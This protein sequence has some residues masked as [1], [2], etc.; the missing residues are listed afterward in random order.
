MP[1]SRS[2]MPT[3]AIITISL[4]IRAI[5]AFKFYVSRFATLARSVSS[6]YS[7]S[8]SRGS[9]VSIV[10]RTMAVTPFIA[11]AIRMYVAHLKNY[12]F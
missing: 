9:V 10:H 2:A 1:T 6:T 5:I 8:I 11:G 7:S 12:N 4:S 3:S